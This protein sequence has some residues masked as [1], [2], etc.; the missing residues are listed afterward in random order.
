LQ[1]EL[2]NFFSNCVFLGEKNKN[3]TTKKQTENSLPNQ[4]IEPG[5]ITASKTTER[6][7]IGQGI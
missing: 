2:Q 5:I 3:T 1:K 4:G 7:D 6:I